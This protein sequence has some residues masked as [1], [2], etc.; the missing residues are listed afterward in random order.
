MSGRGQERKGVATLARHRDA[1]Q[2]MTTRGCMP[3]GSWPPNTPGLP[4]VAVQGPLLEL[5]G[6]TFRTCGSLTAQVAARSQCS[7][8][9]RNFSHK[10]DGGDITSIQQTNLWLTGQGCRLKRAAEVTN[11]DIAFERATRCVAALLGDAEPRQGERLPVIAHVT[12]VHTTEVRGAPDMRLA[13]P[14][15]RRR[16]ELDGGC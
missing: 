6:S 1:N 11:A 3:G 9:G 13:A 16:A 14:G 5:G 7:A 4:P 2:R 10:S 15:R 8:A 12:T